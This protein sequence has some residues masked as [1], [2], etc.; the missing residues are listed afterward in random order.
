MKDFD[1][2]IKD[3]DRR[4]WN[5]KC[6]YV[7]VFTESEAIAIAERKKDVRYNGTKE[8]GKTS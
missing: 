8:P 1:P 6:D 2:R 5:R 3:A 7:C 4:K